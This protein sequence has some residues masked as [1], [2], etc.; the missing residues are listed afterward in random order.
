[1]IKLFV[2]YSLKSISRIQIVYYEKVYPLSIWRYMM[3]YLKFSF[4]IL[5]CLL[6]WSLRGTVLETA[7]SFFAFLTETGVNSFFRDF[8]WF[9]FCARNHSRMLER[10]SGFPFMFLRGFL[11]ML[12]EFWFLAWGGGAGPWEGILLGV[13]VSLTHPNDPKF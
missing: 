4:V 12:A 6:H 2:I 13:G 5:A 9:F 1:M 7:T 8:I 10:G 11:L 3:S